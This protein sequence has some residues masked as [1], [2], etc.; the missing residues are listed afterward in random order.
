MKKII[1]LLTPVFSLTFCTNK[2]G[3]KHVH[4]KSYE[5]SLSHGSH[6][7]ND[8]VLTDSVNIK[9]LKS[10]SFTY[11]Q[12]INGSIDEVFPLYC[13]VK[14]KLWVNGWDPKVVFSNSG[15]IE[16]NCA[17]VT[18]GHGDGH[19]AYWYVTEFNEKDKH[20]EM[21]MTIP[22]TLIMFLIID[23]NPISSDQTKT[24]VT[25]KLTSIG[26]AGNNILKHFTEA[27]FNKTMQ[28]W[29]ESMN[30]YLLTGQLIKDKKG[31]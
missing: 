16:E 25:R 10:V 29:V 27:E 26:N 30:H 5:H 12:I 11:D 24:T 6:M 2:K 15:V 14:E 3:I 4:E 23:A 21:V 28:T 18:K 20:I 17:F 13:P 19:D 31:Y 1:L 8:H 7:E 9:P 22:E